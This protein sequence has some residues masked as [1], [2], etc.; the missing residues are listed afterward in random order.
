LE[1]NGITREKRYGGAENSVSAKKRRDRST[2]TLMTQLGGVRRK[3]IEIRLPEGQ[4]RPPERTMKKPPEGVNS[5]R[6]APL[7]S[8]KEERSGETSK[9]SEK[10]LPKEGGSL[11]G[12]NFGASWNMWK[13]RC[14][15]NRNRPVKGGQGVRITC[16]SRIGFVRGGRGGGTQFEFSEWNCAAAWRGEIVGGGGGG[17]GQDENDERRGKAARG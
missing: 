12:A 9:G 5:P 1:R 14:T 3:I 6:E 2:R 15:C 10:N 17:G 11:R 16:T 7:D 8:A 13:E 4:G